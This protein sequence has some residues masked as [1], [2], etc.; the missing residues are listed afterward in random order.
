[1]AMTK[2]E[3]TQLSSLRKRGRK[4]ATDAK[5]LARDADKVLTDQMRKS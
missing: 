1:V 3:K 5:K 4:I 2:R